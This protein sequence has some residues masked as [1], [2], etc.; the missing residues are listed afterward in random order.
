MGNKENIFSEEDAEKMF[1][2][3]LLEHYRD[4]IEG[5]DPGEPS[6]T[7][8][9]KDLVAFD[10]KI[11]KF[12]LEDPIYALKMFRGCLRRAIEILNKDFPRDSLER[13]RVYISNIGCEFETIKDVLHPAN[14]NRVVEFRGTVYSIEAQQYYIMKAMYLCDVCGIIFPYD[15]DI[16]YRPP[17]SCPNLDCGNT[18]PKKFTLIQEKCI[19]DKYQYV[20]VYDDSGTCR[21]VLRG[22]LVGKVQDNDFV[23]ISG[24]L[25]AKGTP[26]DLRE[27]KYDVYV[28]ALHIEILQRQDIANRRIKYHIVIQTIK[29]LSQEYPGGIPIEEIIKRCEE[30]GIPREFVLMVIERE[31]Y[32]GAIYEPKPGHISIT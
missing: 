18:N 12:F 10:E 6:I 17:K 24:I 20:E 19:Y 29:T 16:I 9:Y 1:A 26:K 23:K 15:L 2:E 27:Q 11:A 28:E 5:I 31:K 22:G 7:I 8:E 30:K 13:A 21:V 14:I 25:L 32:S 3:F 4:I